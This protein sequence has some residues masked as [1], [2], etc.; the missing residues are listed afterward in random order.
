MAL[1]DSEVCVVPW[2]KELDRLSCPICR[3]PASQRPPLPF[4][5]TCRAS[6]TMMLMLG[7]PHGGASASQL[8]LVDIPRSAIR[9]ADIRRREFVL[10]MTREEIASYLGLKLE[11]VSRVFSSLQGSEGLIQVQGRA[12]KLLDAMGLR[13]AMADR[14]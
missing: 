7:K 5:A 13:Q 10:R 11:T 2:G 4:P 3:A 9:C 8:L 6:G 12:V 1:E 14:E